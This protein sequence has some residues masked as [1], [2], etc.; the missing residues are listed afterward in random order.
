M[1]GS[2]IYMTMGFAFAVVMLAYIIV[3]VVAK[4]CR[5]KPSVLSVCR[6]CIPKDEAEYA[7]ICGNADSSY[8]EIRES[9]N[10]M[11]KQFKGLKAAANYKAPETK[12]AILSF[13]NAFAASPNRDRFEKVDELYQKMFATYSDVVRKYQSLRDARLE[14]RNAAIRDMGNILA[15]IDC[16]SEQLV[17]VNSNLP[18]DLQIVIPSTKA[19]QKWVES[20]RN[21]T[22]ESSGAGASLFSEGQ[23]KGGLSGVGMMAVGGL[24]AAGEAIVR[25]AEREENYATAVEA[26]CEDIRKLLDAGASV[27]TLANQMYELSTT[28]RQLHDV[29]LAQVEVLCQR[30]EGMAGATEKRSRRKPFPVMLDE[31]S[32]AVM[33]KLINIYNTTNQY[34][35]GGANE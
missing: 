5:A 8:A 27:N 30:L 6:S 35:T 28:L 34:V 17:S 4:C 9:M 23:A 7:S 3:V 1:S 20:I 12:S 21:Y 13:I 11:E 10:A 19:D 24:V 33:I 29:Y 32:I 25:K 2:S 14:M 16:F 15:L 31:P 26:R 18:K 22:P